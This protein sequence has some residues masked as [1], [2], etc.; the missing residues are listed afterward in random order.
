MA[1]SC[2]YIYN[3]LAGSILGSHTTTCKR[4]ATLSTVSEVSTYCCMQEARELEKSKAVD[5]TTSSERK[6]GTNSQQRDKTLAS[7]DRG[8]FTHRIREGLWSDAR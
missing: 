6:D 5:D 4:M 8:I 3:F 1:N 2:A 7:T